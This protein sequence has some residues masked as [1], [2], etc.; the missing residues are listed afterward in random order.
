V[1][2][3]YKTAALHFFPYAS[4]ILKSLEKN[5]KHWE[6]KSKTDP[7]FVLPPPEKDIA[8]STDAVTNN[9]VN[10]GIKAFVQKSKKRSRK[11]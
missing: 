6:A 10:L 11:S 2:P 8:F 5:A 4:A 9:S 1:Q 7:D 3:L